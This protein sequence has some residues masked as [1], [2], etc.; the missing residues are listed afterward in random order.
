[1]L[2]TGNPAVFHSTSWLKSC[3][4]AP[5]A[6][7]AQSISEQSLY[8]LHCQCPRDFRWTVFVLF[9]DCFAAIPF[10]PAIILSVFESLLSI[11]AMLLS[12]SPSLAAFLNCGIAA[13]TAEAVVSCQLP[14]PSQTLGAL[15]PVSPTQWS[16]G[17]QIWIHLCSL[18]PHLALF[19]D[20]MLVN[21]SSNTDTLRL[22]CDHTAMAALHRH[23][24]SI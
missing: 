19:V 24:K 8:S 21:A 20:F 12:T 18:L 16:S 7:S 6:T 4:G 1:M 2:D 14:V 13:S 3:S 10:L 5:A 11:S 23:K 17:W 9:V 22:S 15:Q